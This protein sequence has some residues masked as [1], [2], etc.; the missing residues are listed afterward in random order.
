MFNE[1]G[2]CQLHM[3]MMKRYDP[4]A[5]QQTAKGAQ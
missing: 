2:R 1:L 3:C 5:G 4:I